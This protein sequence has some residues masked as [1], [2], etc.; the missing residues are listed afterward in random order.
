MPQIVLAKN[1][2]QISRLYFVGVHA[3]LTHEVLGLDQEACHYSKPFG[4]ADLAASSALK[5]HCNSALWLQALRLEYAA[6]STIAQFRFK[7]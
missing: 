1:K 6:T 7:I 2:R 5:R 3:R 4:L